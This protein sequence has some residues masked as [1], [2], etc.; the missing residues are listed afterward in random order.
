MWRVLEGL[1]RIHRWILVL[2][3]QR[4]VVWMSHGLRDIPGVGE[5]HPGDDARTFLARL[6][7]PEQVFPLRSN[8]RDRSHLRRVPLEIQDPNGG[9]LALDLDL[10]RLHTGGGDMLVVFASE[11]APS[12]PGGLDAW[13]IEAL[14]DALI[15]LDGDGFVRRANAAACRLLSC[16]AAEIL[17]RP[18]AALIAPG[19]EQIE[20]LADA[21]RGPARDAR[22]EIRFRAPSARVLTLDVSVTP[23]H[24]GS[25]AL[26]LRDVTSQR[27]AA[28]QLARTNEELDHCIGAL[29]HDLRSPLVGLLG[30]SRLLRQDYDESL[31]DTGRHFV[32]RIEQAART[33]E[34]LIHELLQLARVGEPGERPMLIDCQAILR[35]LAAELKPRLEESGIELVLPSEGTSSV[36]CDRA[37]LYQVLSNLIGNAIDHMGP[38][39]HARIEVSVREDDEGHEIIVSDNGR[40]VDPADRERIFEIFQ[41]AGRR[42]DGRAGTGMGLAIVKKIVERRGGRIWLECGPEGGASFHATFPRH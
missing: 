4:R 28:Q 16:S 36:Y 29:A 27:A 3:E 26:V 8:L 2:D 24:E 22:C 42:A 40:G 5:L 35:Q 1:S 34:S 33:M 38:H 11:R 13:L 6:P 17:A 20:A 37:R 31:D 39:L 32:D 9:T 41:S 15:A 25:R 14:P 7:R 10:I 19:A 21:L 18:I 23:L 12:E 30:F